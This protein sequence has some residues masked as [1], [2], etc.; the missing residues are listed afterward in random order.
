[1]YQGDNINAVV[2]TILELFAAVICASLPALRLLL[3]K[4]FP[5]S[6]CSSSKGTTPNNGQES[7]SK[8]WQTRTDV[9][10]RANHYDSFPTGFVELE[11]TGS[12]EQAEVLP[13]VPPRDTDNGPPF[14]IEVRGVNNEPS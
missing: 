8:P 11:Q 6:L 2:W 10:R 13:E 12:A 9:G 5:K 14:V 3:I 7:R 1:M 4:L